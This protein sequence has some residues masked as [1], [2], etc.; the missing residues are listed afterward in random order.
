MININLNKTHSHK[1]SFDKFK[2]FENNLIKFEYEN[3][4]LKECNN[5]ICFT[6][7][8]NENNGND[9]SNIEYL[10]KITQNTNTDTN[11]KIN[12]N[13]N[14]LFQFDMEVYDIDKIIIND[15][16]IKKYNDYNTSLVLKH[17]TNNTNNANNTNTIKIYAK[18]K[19]FKIYLSNLRYLIFKP[20]KITIEHIY[21]INL[22]NRTDRKQLMT[23]RLKE[24]NLNNYTFIDAINANDI[25]DE[26]SFAKQNKK[27]N[28]VTAGHYACA[29]S[30]IKTLT[31]FLNSQYNY[32]LILEDD[33]LFKK[34][35]IKKIN[36]MYIPDKYD[37]IYFGGLTNYNKLFLDGFSINDSIMGMYAYYANKNIV[38][39]MIDKLSELKTYCDVEFKN[40]FQKNAILLSDI[41]YTNIDD[42]DT[43]EKTQSTC[44]KIEKQ[45]INLIDDD[46]N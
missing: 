43:S 12:T 44:D 36:S 11:T 42:T 32:A 29:K 37:I 31:T 14:I 6:H 22:K 9:N 26:Y 27:T 39:K 24:N 30:H 38:P 46:E 17:N 25:L 5:K 35:F 10:I 4:Q 21:I 3:L 16:N 23:N 40:N 34:N 15:K 41:I 33:V 18:N 13:E 20:Q 7:I 8:Y 1:I 28:I 2:Y 19:N 45:L